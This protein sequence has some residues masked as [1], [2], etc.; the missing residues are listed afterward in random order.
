MTTTLLP[1]VIKIVETIEPPPWSEIVKQPTIRYADWTFVRWTSGPWICALV[2]KMLGGF[3]RAL[4][5][6]RYW[7]HLA[8]GDFPGPSQWHRDHERVNPGRHRLYC[9]GAGAFTQFFPDFV[10]PEGA[11]VEYGDMHLHRV[12]AATLSGPRLFV[13]VS[14]ADRLPDNRFMPPPVFRY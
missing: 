4:I 6:V 2:D 7:S 12:Q 10:S 8:A 1:G 9:A 13:R 11:I 5:D 14:E 3:G